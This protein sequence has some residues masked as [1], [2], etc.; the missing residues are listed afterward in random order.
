[1]IQGTTHTVEAVEG[2]HIKKS[3]KLGGSQT[4]YV[5][6]PVDHKRRVRV[7]RVEAD[8]VPTVDVDD[9][10]LEEGVMLVDCAGPSAV[11]SQNC[12]Q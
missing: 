11:E 7:P 12:G 3:G 4:L 10:S 6:S 8:E 9:E 5:P 1:M 2:G